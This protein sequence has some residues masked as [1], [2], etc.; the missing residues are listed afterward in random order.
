MKTGDSNDRLFSTF[1]HALSLHACALTGAPPSLHII[2]RTDLITRMSAPSPRQTVWFAS[3]CTDY[4][5]VKS[6]HST[7]ARAE[8]WL[9]KQKAIMIEAAPNGHKIVD[10][11]TKRVKADVSDDE[12]KEEWQDYTREDATDN[13]EEMAVDE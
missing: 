4:D 3:I 11:V 12:L 10:P 6:V 2:F 1:V 5:T 13:V 9:L 7:K 8:K